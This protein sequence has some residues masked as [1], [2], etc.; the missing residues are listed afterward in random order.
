MEDQEYERWKTRLVRDVAKKA[1]KTS[2]TFSAAAH[3][4]A[5]TRGNPHDLRIV[6]LS[7]H[8]H[9]LKLVTPGNPVLLANGHSVFRKY[10][11]DIDKRLG[12][13]RK[14]PPGISAI[15]PEE[16]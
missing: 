1:I 5:E 9:C 3:R 12:L 10:I 6:L 14:Q 2:H 8:A 11:E 7:L 13:N 15:E 4:I 16:E